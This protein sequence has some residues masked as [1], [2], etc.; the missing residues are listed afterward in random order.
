[1]GIKEIYEII[2]ILIPLILELIRMFKGQ[3]TEVKSS[4]ARAARTAAKERCE[5]GGVGC[6]PE[7][8]K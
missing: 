1:M 7:V 2:K 6:A 3:P 5:L 4:A 8:K